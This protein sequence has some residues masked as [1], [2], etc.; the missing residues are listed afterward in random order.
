MLHRRVLNVDSMGPLDV[1]KRRR[2]ASQINSNP[3]ERKI[4]NIV[5]D[6]LF[7]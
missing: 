1:S 2:W 4:Y 3:G 7:F 5:A 6:N